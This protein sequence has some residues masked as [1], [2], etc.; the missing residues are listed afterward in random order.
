MCLRGGVGRVEING[1]FLD[2]GSPCLLRQDLLLNLGL[3]GCLGLQL[4]RATA[5]VFSWMLGLNSDPHP[6]I[7][8]PFPTEP[9]TAVLCCFPH[10]QCLSFKKEAYYPHCEWCGSLR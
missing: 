7:G 5:P 9:I 8:G 3:F 1:V 6:S 4:P 2:C 10:I